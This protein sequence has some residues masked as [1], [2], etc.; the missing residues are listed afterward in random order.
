M[1]IRKT[2]ELDPRDA[3]AYYNR[4]TAYLDKEDSDRAIQDLTKAIELNPRFT[5][6]YVNRSAAYLDKRGH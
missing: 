4:G 5:Q 6:A 3:R 2:I 1:K